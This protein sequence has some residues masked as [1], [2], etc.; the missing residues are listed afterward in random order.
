MRQH[1]SD[2]GRR[3]DG[4]HR[5]A[6]SGARGAVFDITNSTLALGLL[7]LFEFLPA[8]VLLP[9]TGSA[10]DRFNRR[11]VVAIAMAA[12]VVTSLLYL[13]Y[14]LTRPTSAIPIFAIALLFGTARAFAAP[15]FRAGVLRKLDTTP[16]QLG[17]PDANAIRLAQTG[18]YLEAPHDAVTTN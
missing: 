16:E 17:L 15:A 9:L 11:R 13:G 2:R 3:S 10:A 6:G 18:V 4:R 14:A 7:G 12:E 8:L 5:D 1:F